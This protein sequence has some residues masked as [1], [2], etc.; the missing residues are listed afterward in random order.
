[1]KEKLKDYKVPEYSVDNPQ[2]SVLYGGDKV[3]S[4]AAT[5]DGKTHTL[6]PQWDYDKDASQVTL[7][8]NIEEGYHIKNSQ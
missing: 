7:T 1:M 8:V 2:E 4:I 3:K 6:T 5:K